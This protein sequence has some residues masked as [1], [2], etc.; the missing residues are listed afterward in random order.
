M[1]EMSPRRTLAEV[2]WDDLYVLMH[3]FTPLL[4]VYNLS[5]LLKPL[6][7]GWSDDRGPWE[8]LWYLIVKNT[9][10]DRQTL[11]IY[12]TFLVTLVAY[13]IGAVFFLALDYAQWPHFLYKYKINPGKNA[14][15]EMSKVIKL[16]KVV[17]F[18]LGMCLPLMHGGWHCRY[19][20]CLEADVYSVPSVYSLLGYLTVAA[21][22]HDV[23]FYHAHR[24][25]HHKAVYK[26]IHKMHHEW[27]SPIAAAAIYCHPVEHLL[28]GLLP[29]SAGFALTCPPIPV[30]WLWFVWF[31]FMVQNDHSGFHLPF[32]HSPEF[33]DFHHARFHTCFGWFNFWDW[34][35]QTDAQFE[36]SPVHKERHVVLKDLRSARELVPDDKYKNSNNDNNNNKEQAS[37][38]KYD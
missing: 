7:M 16:V 21:L 38:H 28:S 9:T 20:Q 8:Y 4:V 23:L 13:V 32:I 5:W 26:H 37:L 3:Y 15:P 14:P 24:L 18:N 30:A 2:L 1:K 6:L 33:H 29:S 27:V 22:C 34:Y 19:N 11:A 10:E 17:S 12:G 35:Y 36:R 31:N 25:L